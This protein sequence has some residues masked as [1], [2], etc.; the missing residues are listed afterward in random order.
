VRS[1]EGDE[2]VAMVTVAFGRTSTV[3]TVQ[4]R[5]T[6]CTRQSQNPRKLT[7]KKLKKIIFFLFDQCCSVRKDDSFLV[8]RECQN[9]KTGLFGFFQLFLKHAHRPHEDIF[10]H[11][12]RMKV[13]VDLFVLSLP[14]RRT[15]VL[16]CIK[17]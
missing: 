2:A 5:V 12:L 9:A 3:Q 4:Y 14:G 13:K 15:L 17:T 6:Q 10:F 16:P 1:F 11:T 7:L 8:S